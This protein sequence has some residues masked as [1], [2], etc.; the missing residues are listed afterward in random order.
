M[1]HGAQFVGDKISGLFFNSTF[2]VFTLQCTFVHVLLSVRFRVQGCIPLVHI[3]F[4]GGGAWP[5]LL[6]WFGPCDPPRSRFSFQYCTSWITCNPRWNMSESVHGCTHSRTRCDSKRC[7]FVRN[8]CAV[9][10][11]NVIVCETCKNSENC[12]TAR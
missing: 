12:Y 9:A 3:F 10:A 2:L 11:H 6:Y 8:A 4:G 7:K 5:I 1:H